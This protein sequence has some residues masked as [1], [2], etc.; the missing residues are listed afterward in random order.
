MSYFIR[1]RNIIKNTIDNSIYYYI[2][3]VLLFI[4]GT[5]VGSLMANLLKHETTLKIVNVISPYIELKTS[6]LMS[7]KNTLIINYIFIGTAFIFG[8]LNLGFLTTSLVFLRGSLLG[9]TIGFIIGNYGIKGF[10]LSI[11]G[12]YPQ[13]II[14]L[15]CLIFIGVLCIVFDRRTNLI[16][17]KRPGRVK[18]NLLDYIFLF[19]LIT[20]IMTIGVFYEG[21]ISPIFFGFK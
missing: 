11:F 4:A 7:L 2:I 20:I 18:I 13:Y 1:L 15:P 17:N 9:I 19:A 12:I 8:L 21:L 14:Y 5:I 16:S 6:G 3:L 10:F